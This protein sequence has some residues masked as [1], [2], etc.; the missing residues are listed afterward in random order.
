MADIN[1]Y[2]REAVNGP[3][4]QH[5]VF[6]Q[7]EFEIS[8]GSDG[9]THTKI[10]DRHGDP[11]DPREIS[12]PTDYPDKDVKRSVDAV[13]DAL[14]KIPSEEISDKFDDLIT[15][16]NDNKITL[17]SDYPDTAVKEELESIKATQKEILE[18]LDKPIDTQVTGS[19]VDYNEDFETVE[20]S[21]GSSLQLKKRITTLGYDRLTLVSRSDTNHRHRIS[22]LKADLSGIQLSNKTTA[23]A[24]GNY[25]VVSGTMN[26]TSPKI[27]VWL[28]NESDE[29]KVYTAGYYLFQ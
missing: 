8:E 14:E 25:R 18:R 1:A 7:E 2:L 3:A 12:F 9:A 19:K 28:S 13:K 4:P 22:V 10:V 16:T 15:I 11:I 20:I 21:P 27:R 29:E 17:P 26:V 5:K 6:G 23:V 24:E